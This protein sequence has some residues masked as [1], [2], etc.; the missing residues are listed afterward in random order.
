MKIQISRSNMLA[1]EMIRFAITHLPGRRIAEYR[2]L[3]LNLKSSTPDTENFR[4]IVVSGE[5]VAF[6]EGLSIP[7]SP[8]PSRIDH[9]LRVYKF[10]GTVT[11]ER[12]GPD[13]WVPNWMDFYLQ[14]DKFSHGVE[15]T[16]LCAACGYQGEE[17]RK[18]LYQILLSPVEK[19]KLV[20]AE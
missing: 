14:A 18:G 11:V 20:S 5:A 8:F 9:E 2:L 1:E 10:H 6:E 12:N 7:F 19:S 3:E 17:S 4:V 16:N 15:F 13:C